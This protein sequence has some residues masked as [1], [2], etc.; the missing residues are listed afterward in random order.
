MYRHWA[1]FGIEHVRT[2]TVVEHDGYSWNKVAIANPRL[3]WWLE[4]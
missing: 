1:Q 3:H 4:W 2:M